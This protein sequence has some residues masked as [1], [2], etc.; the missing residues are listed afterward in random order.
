[1]PSQR[2]R[3]QRRYRDAYHRGA[4]TK[5]QLTREAKYTVLADEH[6]RLYYI[7]PQ[8]NINTS[9]G[10]GHEVDCYVALSRTEPPI[11][12]AEI[13]DRVY[14]FPEEGEKVTLTVRSLARHDRLTRDTLVCAIVYDPHR[15][16]KCSTGTAVL[17]IERT[18]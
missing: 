9:E 2:R 3:E 12:G 11:D 17:M 7:E 6:K 8:N 14:S 16:R 18:T 1:M 13:D 10:D 15:H 5:S 4:P